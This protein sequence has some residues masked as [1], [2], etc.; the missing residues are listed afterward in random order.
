MNFNSNFYNKIRILSSKAILILCS[1]ILIVSFLPR[2][3]EKLLRYDI[4]KPWSYG[5]IIAKFDFPVYKTDEALQKEQDSVLRSFMSYY[6]KD[7]EIEAKNLYKF[8]KKFGSSNGILAKD[9]A[10]KVSRKLAELYNS[11]I[12]YTKEHG[13]MLKD[14]SKVIRVV[15]GKEAMQ[16]PI[17][18]VYSTK[19]AYEHLLSDEQLLPFRSVLMR[20]NLTDYIEPNLLYDSKRSETEKAEL[21]SVIP[22]ASGMVVSG[23]KIIDRGEIV[24]EY[25]YRVLNSFEREADRRNTS[26]TNITQKL[27]GQSIFVSILVVLFT[28]YLA[29]YRKDYSNKPSSIMMLY[30]LITLFPIVV[31]LMMKQT[32]LNVYVLPIAMIPIFT[33]VFMD[34]RTAFITHIIAVL[35][36]AVAVK[37]QYEFIITQIV[38]GMVSI[39]AL[40]ELSQRSQVFKASVLVSLTQASMYFAMQLMQNNSIFEIDYGV[41]YYFL[42]NGILLLL[43]YPLM[44]VV[45]KTFGFISEVTLIELSDTNKGLI[46]Q[47]SEVAPGTFQH[48]ITVANLSADI[49]NKIGARSLLLRTGALYHDIGKMINPVF[50]TENQAGSNPHEGLPYR[51]SA[52]IIISHVTEGLKMADKN[53][54]PQFIIDF[55]S[56]H[57]GKGMTKFFYIKEQ[58]EHPNEEIDKAPFT[59][60]G[61]NPFTREQ[62]IL[63]MTDTVE[64]ASRSLPEYTEESIS[65]LVNSLIDGQIS[66]GFFTNCPITYKDITI[67]KQVL[68]D[69]LM[70]IYHTRVSYPTLNTPEKA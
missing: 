23:Q 42:G 17:S 1:V 59:Y 46:R 34:A 56:T 50:F 54:L 20:C 27:V 57:H 28:V 9:I 35:L 49:A 12:V 8:N 32:L 19:S 37:Y 61:P 55:I 40:R 16:V 22:E 38:A 53:G 4:G 24:D 45:E 11:G 52:K 70:S 66:S 21:L 25:T 62:A 15:S 3:K 30:G 36:C 64:A 60:P 51:D 47:M 39:Y 58:N 18:T 26:S 13:D 14:S 10:H 31:S 65:N 69:R 33:R 41:Y 48:S 68:T 2:N 6:N 5:S 29:L 7:S 44:Y 43:S 67:A 63:M